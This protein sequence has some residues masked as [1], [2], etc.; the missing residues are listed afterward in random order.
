M[1]FHKVFNEFI[2]QSFPTKIAAAKKTD[3]S[4]SAFYRFCSPDNNYN[5]SKKT[6]A[7]LEESFGRRFV[8]D[9]SGEIIDFVSVI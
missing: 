1:C 9:N 2:D 5:R 8:Y 3:F 4:Q 6:L 7:K